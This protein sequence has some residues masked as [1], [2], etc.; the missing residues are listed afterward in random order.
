MQ[1]DVKAVGAIVGAASA[2]GG[3]SS[4]TVAT[5]TSSAPGILG[6]LGFAT[7]TT[8]ALP[9]AGIVAVAGLV[10][11]GLSKGKQQARRY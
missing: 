6:A 5:I 7:T 4:V 11:Y 10:G 3:T 2:V 9:V 8:V 1:N